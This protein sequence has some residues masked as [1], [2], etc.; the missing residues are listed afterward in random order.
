MSLEKGN[1]IQPYLLGN[2]TTFSILWP[3]FQK[4]EIERVSSK[5]L[6]TITLISILFP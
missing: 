3:C 6:I 5:V 2:S 1:L 4:L